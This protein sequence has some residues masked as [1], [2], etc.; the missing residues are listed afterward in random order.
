[1]FEKTSTEKPRIE[2]GDLDPASES[3]LQVLSYDE[4]LL[5]SGAVKPAV[6]SCGSACVLA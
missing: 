3:S 4:I 2:P 1:M 6:C 5:V